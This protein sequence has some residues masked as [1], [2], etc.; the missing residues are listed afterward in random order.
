MRSNFF[1][2]FAGAF[3]LHN[4]PF[5]IAVVCIPVYLVLAGLF[6]ALMWYQGR[7]ATWRSATK[8]D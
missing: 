3:L 7:A 8:T 2:Q 1:C 6:S 4:T 5:I